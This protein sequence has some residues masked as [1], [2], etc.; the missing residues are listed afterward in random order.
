[1][2]MTAT[3]RPDFS[4]LSVA[5]ASI[6]M[7][8]RYLFLALLMTGCGPKTPEKN[9]NYNEH[10]QEPGQPEEFNLVEKPDPKGGTLEK[11]DSYDFVV[12]EAA[13]GRVD[14]VIFTVAGIND[15]VR[16][17]KTVYTT[18]LDINKSEI[19]NI[20]EGSVVK[21]KEGLMLKVVGITGAEAPQK[22]KVFF[23]RM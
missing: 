13:V 7:K 14:D 12:S 2:S 10:T 5:E 15:E 18:Y 22:G 1:M 4:G 11:S 8:I 23:K 17:G 21:M 9:M 6:P 20:E 3:D 19:V 16:D